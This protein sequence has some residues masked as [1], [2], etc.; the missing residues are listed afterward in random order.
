MRVVAPLANEG[1][2]GCGPGNGIGFHLE[3]EHAGDA[4]VVAHFTPGLEHQGWDGIMHGGLV[5][6]LLD[7]AMAW[8]AAASTRIYLTARME[9]RY[10]EPVRIGTPLLVRG[11]LTRDRR[12]TLETR[13]EVQTLSGDVL[14]E[15][16]ALYVLAPTAK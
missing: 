1:C 10:R 16:T 2:F 6:T 14:A 11:W 12:R 4:G 8:A 3:F 13:A 9:V 7:E 15:A 5:S